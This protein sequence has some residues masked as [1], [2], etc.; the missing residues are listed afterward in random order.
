MEKDLMEDSSSESE[1][2]DD[3]NLSSIFNDPYATT[4]ITNDGKKRWRCEWCKKD[5]ALWNATKAMYHLIQKKK[6]DIAP[7]QAQIDDVSKKRYREL[8][9]KKKK[10]W[11]SVARKRELIDTSIDA[12]NIRGAVSLESAKQKRRKVMKLSQNEMLSMKLSY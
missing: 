11:D 5:F 9:Y 1:K 3:N 10:R 4:Y 6:V 2:E 12:T 8:Y 7:C